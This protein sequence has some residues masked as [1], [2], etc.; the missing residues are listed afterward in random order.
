MTPFSTDAGAIAGN[1]SPCTRSFDYQA[2]MDGANPEV[3]MVLGATTAPLVHASYI[4]LIG[5]FDED[6][7]ALVAHFAH[8]LKG[9]VAYF[10]AKPVY[11]CLLGIERAAKAGDMAA[12]RAVLT[13][14]EAE[15]ACFLP[16]LKHRML[17]GTLPQ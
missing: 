12:A 17:G 4:D 8:T 7:A 10:G 5:A 15:M 13:Q 6:D 1:A 11:G 14:L 2:G 9:M 16:V 3:L